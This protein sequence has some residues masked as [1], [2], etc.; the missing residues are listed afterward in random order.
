MKSKEKLLLFDYDGTIVDSIGYVLK[1]FNQALK[2]YGFK[3]TP[4]GKL[5]DIYKINLYDSLI[6]IGIDED[7]LKSFLVDWVSYLEAYKGDIKVFEGM[8]ETI[9]KLSDDFKVFVVTSN[10]TDFV[11]NCLKEFRFKGIDAVIGGDKGTSKSDKIKDL[12]KNKGYN[13]VFYIGDS[14]GDILE[15]NKAGVKSVSVSW[16]IHSRRLLESGSPT[17]LVDK[18]EE[19]LDIFY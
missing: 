5:R 18:P 11:F 19:L 9:E 15:S 12:L 10:H 14:L 7:I 13:E 16:G 1:S 17:Y 6:K 4:M 3:E 8:Q 2:K